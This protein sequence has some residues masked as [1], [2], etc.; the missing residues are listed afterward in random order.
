MKT[1]VEVSDLKILSWPKCLF[2]H[3]IVWNNPNELFGQHR[4]MIFNLFI[5]RYTKK[6][7]FIGLRPS[8][9]K[10]RHFCFYK[11]TVNS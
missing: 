8:P 10:K 2:F 9:P 5:F 11:H 1:G 4:Q 7:Q 6:V 3:A